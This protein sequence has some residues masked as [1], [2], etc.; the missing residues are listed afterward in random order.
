MQVAKHRKI[1]NKRQEMY[2]KSKT[3]KIAQKNY[4]KQQLPVK[5]QEEF[6]IIQLP[7]KEKAF[8][9]ELDCKFY[10]C[11]SHLFIYLVITRSFFK[12][13]ILPRSDHQTQGPVNYLVQGKDGEWEIVQKTDRDRHESTQ[14][15][16]HL[17]DEQVKPFL[18]NS[19]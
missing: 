11:N 12:V 2:K 15:T 17:D 13:A 14:D 8:V 4:N 5:G 6:K 7:A 1:L 9:P 18:L 16:A 3:K 19:H 10:I